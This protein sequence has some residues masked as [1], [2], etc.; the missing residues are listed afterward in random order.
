M[1]DR[2]EE[3]EERLKGTSPLISIQSCVGTPECSALQSRKQRG[4]LMRDSLSSPK[5]GTSQRNSSLSVAMAR[6]NFEGDTKR[7]VSREYQ[8]I[9]TRTR[10]PSTSLKSIKPARS[11]VLRNQ[12]TRNKENALVLCEDREDSS[13][14]LVPKNSSQIPV[15]LKAEAPREII[16]TPCKNP[17][18]SPQ[19]NT[20]FLAKDSNLT[21]FTAWDVDSRLHTMESMF[22]E[23]KKTVN[24]T[25]NDR[26]G[27]EEVL[28]LHK[29][30]G[31]FP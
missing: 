25:A 12:K 20:P 29:T 16:A 28:N 10:P 23:M 6:L 5:V 22:S 3:E 2:S 4:T 7:S 18:L 8:A 26:A 14:A 24:M 19:K 31:T 27:F 21:G 13:V 17:K 9:S 15:P 30:R 1:G 11:A